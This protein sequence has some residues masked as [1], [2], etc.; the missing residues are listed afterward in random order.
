MAQHERA[1]AGQ[2]DVE[3][4]PGAAE[5]LGAAQTGQRVFRRPSRRPAMSDDGGELQGRHASV[6]THPFGAVLRITYILE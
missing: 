3:F 1:V 4:D 2:P 6:E 5:R